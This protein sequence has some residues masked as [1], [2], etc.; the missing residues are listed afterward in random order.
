VTRAGAEQGGRQGVSNAIIA[1]SLLAMEFIVG[2]QTYVLRTALPIVGS[3]LDAHQYYGVIVGT[4]QI[5]MFLTMPL[6]P[7]LLQR[8]R[9]DRVFLY[10]TWVSV[11]GGVISAVAP[12]TAIFVLGRAIAGLAGGATSTVSLAA[13]VTVLPPGWRRAV[14][15]GYNVM[16]VC[17]SLLGPL[18][19]SWVA[20]ALSWR[21]ALVLYLPL[22]LVARIV[23]AHQLKGTQQSG[24]GKEPLPL[25]SA[26]LLAGGVALVSVT[27]IQHLS[28]VLA[29][30]AGLVG[31]AAALAAARVLLPEG[32]MRIRR[33]RPAAVATMG[34][35]TGSY[36]GAAEI[37]SIV[38]EE[39]FWNLDG[40]PTRIT[41]PH[42]PLPSAGELED[43]TIPTV[44]R[45]VETTR[46]AL[47]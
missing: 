30:G 42:V 28:G 22:M 32:T 23:L 3:D 41:T 6:G 15:A 20:S 5:A 16:W 1:A 46:K 27:G 38:V 37:V 18:Y 12:S 13:I 17:T 39:C 29:I 33:G 14:L 40:P 8:F 44:D 4:F 2:M 9:V 7:Y 34:V 26:A 36:F 10:L 45:I 11:A 47:H 24:G 35:L 43:A 19:G 25:G 31:T 21:W